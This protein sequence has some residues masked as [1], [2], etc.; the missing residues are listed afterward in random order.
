MAFTSVATD[1]VDNYV[2][3]VFSNV[4]VRDLLTGTTS[5]VS[6]SATGV[7]AYGHSTNP[8]ISD[9][10]RYVIFQSYAGN[11][12]D[13]DTNGFIDVFVRD[14]SAG[15]TELVSVSTTG[16]SGN[17]RS[18]GHSINGDGRYVAFVSS[19]SNLSDN[20]E[21]GKEDV[22]V[23]DLENHTTTLVSASFDNA[24]SDD[25][26]YDPVISSDGR[27]V[28]FASSATN[29]V[30]DD[31]NGTSDVFVRD[32][33]AGDHASKYWHNWRKWLRSVY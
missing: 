10:G 23:R 30:D 3:G 5:L 7:E 16:S 1:I 31:T 15:T 18:F 13:N 17:G 27:Y 32:L 11:L 26:S 24:S 9:N 29:L 33:L 12:V 8:I 14:L 6:I 19:S 20:D 28:A 22:F 4:F 25:Y 2:S 21:N